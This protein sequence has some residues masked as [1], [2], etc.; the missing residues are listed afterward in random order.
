VID[1][2]E[3][4][5]PDGEAARVTA[6][7]GVM[8]PHYFDFQCPS[9]MTSSMRASPS[10]VGLYTILPS[11]ILYGVYHKKEGRWVGVNCAMV[12]Q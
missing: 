8:L 12:V 2:V 11:P 9:L 10:R 4:D 1:V 5:D 7:L 3:D 6:L